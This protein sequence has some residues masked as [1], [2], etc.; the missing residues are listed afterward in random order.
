MDRL[1]CDGIKLGFCVEQ[2]DF[3]ASIIRCI[4]LQWVLNRQAKW[5]LRWR[6]GWHSRWQFRWKFEL[7][8]TTGCIAI[9]FG[10]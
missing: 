5:Q 3:C 7:F 8:V 9:R 10:G 4:G 2:P 1:A 6:F